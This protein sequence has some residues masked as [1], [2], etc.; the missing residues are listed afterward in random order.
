M[1]SQGVPSSVY[2]LQLT[3]DFNLHDA[4]KLL[5]YLHDLGIEGVYCSPYFQANSPHGYD[6]TDPN[7]LN[8]LVA[9]ERQYTAFCKEVKRLGMFHI[10]DVVPN[11]MG[12]KGENLWFQDVLKRGERS[13]YAPFFDLYWEEG[14][15]L[16]PVLGEPFEKAL[17]SLRVIREKGELWLELYDEVLP[18]HSP[19][20]KRIPYAK[21]DL[22]ALLAKQHYKL[23]HWKESAKKAGYRRFFTI[24]ELIALRIEEERVLRAHHKLIFELL[25]E[26]AVDGL[27]IDHPDGLYDPKEYFDRL[28]KKHKGLIVVEKILAFEEELPYKWQVEGTVG[29][30]FMNLLTGLFVKK[31]QK[32]LVIYEKFTGES[33]DFEERL[34]KN[35]LCFLQTEMAGDVEHLASLLPREDLE[36]ALY[37]LLASFPVY[38]TYIR[39]EGGV[40][41]RDL[42]YIEKAFARARERIGSTLALEELEK[43][44]LLEEDT[45]KS[46]DFLMRF[47]QLSAPAMAKGFEDITLYQYNP[48]IAL[49]EVGSDPDRL[50]TTPREFHDFCQK[51]QRHWPL[52]FLATS[53][54]DTKRSLD[55][56]MQIACISECPSEW[57]EVL[58]A[59]SKASA[60]FKTKVGKHLFPDPN[61]EIFLYQ[62]LL[63]VFPSKPTFQRLWT[64]FEKSIRE[65]RTY[66]NWREPHPEIE[67]AAKRFLREI[68]K[69][70]SPFM[71][72]FLPFQATLYEKGLA[73]SLAAIA[74]KLGAP[75]IVDVYEGCEHPRYTLVDPDNR[76]PVDF[77]KKPSTKSLLHKY[78]LHFRKKHKELFLEGKY[79]PLKTKGP[80]S[81]NLVAY[82]RIHKSQTL[83]VAAPCIMDALPSLEETRILLPKKMGEGESI[84]TSQVF[85][86]KEI[87]ARALFEE[88]P[89]AWV[90]WASGSSPQ[91]Q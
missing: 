39:K 10:A 65:A 56:R 48:M 9:T 67:R 41:S 32:L 2:R 23:V 27:R 35:K 12:I 45:E 53:T 83:L 13:R 49:N 36:E 52:G 11:H 8:P 22:R 37:H 81:K 31:E 20:S 28:R 34:Y 64:V 74:L 18:L 24:N 43:I 87:N 44:F 84:F 77:S 54:H 29:Y 46:R 89:F 17:D 79:I 26:K 25:K 30:E 76:T 90:F 33:L 50:G 62:T 73:K 47:Q 72:V 6:I 4:K 86:G 68:L 61:T 75:G 59:L 21:E 3:E 42:P 69:P 55:T 91:D 60:P 40:P 19:K 38:R 63:G 58:E 5:P 51:K 82:M 1:R 71:E 57:E 66:T 88:L 70:D 80:H 14:K 78:A 16:L 7:A 15:V 85:S